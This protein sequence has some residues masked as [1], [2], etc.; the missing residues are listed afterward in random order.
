R[1]HGLVH[2]YLRDSDPTPRDPFL[3]RRRSEGTRLPSLRPVEYHPKDKVRGEVLE[4][5]NL[6]GR[7]EQKRT[8]LDV[9]A[10]LPIEEEPFATSDEIDLVSRVRL[11]WVV[12]NRCVKLH[13]QGT[14][15]ENGHCQ[16]PR[17]RG[18]FGKGVGKADMDD[19]F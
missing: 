3:K 6:T 1:L 16:I 19:L 11:L 15:G 4:A 17:R 8:A 18:A 13:H 9:V 12:V 14:V 2:R 7:N 10:L 5:V